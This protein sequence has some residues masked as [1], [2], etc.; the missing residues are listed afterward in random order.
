ML[1]Y[2]FLDCVMHTGVRRAASRKL[3][4]ELGIPTSATPPDSFTYLTRIH[5]LA[6][7]DGLW[8]EHES[9]RTLPFAIL[10]SASFLLPSF[11]SGRAC[12]LLSACWNVMI[13]RSISLLSPSSSRPHSFH[14]FANRARGQPKRGLGHPLC[15][16]ARAA[17]DVR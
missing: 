12:M 7:S 4:H 1:I 15:L 8:G 17:G 2:D 10:P 3:E 13:S 11:V 6:P 14:H 9:K 5:Y 16:Q